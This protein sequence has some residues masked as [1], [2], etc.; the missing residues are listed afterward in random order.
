MNFFSMPKKNLK[1]MD[2]EFSHYKIQESLDPI[3][4]KRWFQL[5]RYL[6][7]AENKLQRRLLLKSVPYHC[8]EEM[9]IILTDLKINLQKCIDIMT[10][11]KKQVLEKLK[12][13]MSLCI[14]CFTEFLDCLVRLEPLL[15]YK[16][17]QNKSS[18]K[19]QYFLTSA[20]THY[21]N[22][23]YKELLPHC[24]WLACFYQ[25]SLI[26]TFPKE[27]FLKMLQSIQDPLSWE[28]VLEQNG[29][30]TL[31]CHPFLPHPLDFIHSVYNTTNHE[32]KWVQTCQV[33]FQ[34]H[35]GHLKFFK[36]KVIV[37]MF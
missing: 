7:D 19:I 16:T 3:P 28:I 5:E 1:P 18:K 32:N 34:S 35:S 37:Q 20:R 36:G 4:Y 24:F 22:S 27:E 21:M 11:H 12:Q 17:C 8:E 15:R 30:P 26:F 14:Q 25:N 31:M 9:I 2:Y 29:Q 23:F 6:K 33:L 13:E 10:N